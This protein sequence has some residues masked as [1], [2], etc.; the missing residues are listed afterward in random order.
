MKKLLICAIAGAALSSQASAEM[1]WSTASLSYL[2]GGNY[3]V[4]DHDRQ[5]FT[6]EHASS[7]SWGDNFFFMDR[8][9]SKD[10]TKQSYSELAPRLSL[11]KISGKDFSLGPVSDV[12]LAGQW[13]SGE[14]FDNFMYGFGVNLKV[15]GFK[16]VTANIYHV[17]NEKT[18]NNNQLTVTYAYP[19]TVANSEF[20]YDG[21][22]DY[23]TKT[24]SNAGAEMNWTSQL[25]WNAGKL[26][27]TKSPVY[28]GVEY[29]YWNNKFGIKNRDERNPALLLKWHF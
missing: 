8:L 5:V 27:G 17:N 16:Y 12:L 1:L 11:G 28:V 24:S 23:S 20:L 10:G 26:I 21:F 15:P 14:G 9:N 22:M 18:D 29:A 2:K 13:E 4:G 25:K 6:I 7:H 19:F 3:Q